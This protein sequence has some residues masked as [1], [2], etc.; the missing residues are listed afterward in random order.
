MGVRPEPVVGQIK[1]QGSV[2]R[3]V[4]RSLHWANLTDGTVH[5]KDIVYTPRD[6]RA[7]VTFKNGKTLE[8]EPDSMVQFDELNSGEVEISL[9]N[10]GTNLLPVPKDSKMG[11]LSDI[12]S[13]ELRQ[14]EL[15]ARLAEYSRHDLGLKEP[16]KL[17]HHNFDSGRLSDFELRL[18]KTASGAIQ[19][20][21]KSL[22]HNGLDA[23]AFERCHL[24]G[25]GF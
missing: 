2:R 18:L 17:K 11:F 15:S 25:G 8:M 20:T 22:A 5:L 23:G 3:R 7:V 9:L 24:Q 10:L 13:L 21:I 14:G 12:R 19:F 4:A 6:S 16:Q 1:V